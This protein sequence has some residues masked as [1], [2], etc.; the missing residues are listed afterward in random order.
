MS[1][2]KTPFPV[3]GGHWGSSARVRQVRKE[4]ATVEA[5]CQ[6]GQLFRTVH[7]RE[8]GHRI[9]IDA[10][11]ICHTPEVLFESMDE[12]ANGGD[13]LAGLG[14]SQSPAL[15]GPFHTEPVNRGFRDARLVLVVGRR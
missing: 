1:P 12:P 15:I 4:C 6:L 14:V 13:D 7:G 8:G 5:L 9:Q 2:I 10:V 3:T 11:V